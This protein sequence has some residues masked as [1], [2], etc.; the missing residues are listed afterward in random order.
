MGFHDFG[1]MVQQSYAVK[2]KDI[3]EE[4]EITSSF[5]QVFHD[6]LQR[7]IQTEQKC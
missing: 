3:E 2:K 6:K 4:V 1:Q 7:V 5:Q